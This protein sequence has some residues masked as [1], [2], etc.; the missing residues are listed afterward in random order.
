M[1][2]NGRHSWTREELLYC[3]NTVNPDIHGY[4]ARLFDLWHT[5]NPEHVDY[6]IQRLAGQVLSV[7]RRKV[8]TE[9]EL[10]EIQSMVSPV[11]H[12]T[13]DSAAP[14]L[15]VGYG[16]LP[17]SDVNTTAV[18]VT[19][20]NCICESSPLDESLILLKDEIVEKY[21]F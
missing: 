2:G 8:F 19:D 11:S 7:L 21:E 10:S 15:G 9:L 16:P 1:V 13:E 3:F 12:A 4:Q 18:A 6:T 20:H 17:S 5:R 14:N